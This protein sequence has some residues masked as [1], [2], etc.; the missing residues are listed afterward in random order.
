MDRVTID[1][2]V[3]AATTCDQCT[4]PATHRVLLNNFPLYFVCVPH[5][6]LVLGFIETHLTGNRDAAS[7]SG[8]ES[9]GRQ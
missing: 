2:Q 1:T 8:D 3:D 4:D 9:S 7:R 6:P 5:V